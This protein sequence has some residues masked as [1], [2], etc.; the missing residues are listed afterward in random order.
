MSKIYQICFEQKDKELV[1]VEEE[2]DFA[3]TYCELL[4]TRFEDKR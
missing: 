1:S 4:K 2:L 3:K